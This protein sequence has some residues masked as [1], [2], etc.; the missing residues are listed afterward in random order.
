MSAA[1]RP[2]FALLFEY[3]VRS[4]DLTVVTHDGRALRFGD[5]TGR[6]V[7]IRFAD[8]KAGRELLLDPALKAGELFMDRRLLIE[9]GTVYDLLD[10]MLRDLRNMQAPAVFRAFDALKMAVWRWFP[11]NKAKRSREN[12][13]HHYDLNEALY[14][15][16]L[17]PDYQYS[18]AYFEDPAQSLEDAQLA[19]KRHIAAKLRLEPSSRVLD[20]G[21]GWGGL[22]IYLARTAGAARVTGTSLSKEQ[23]E[24]SRTRVRDAGLED[25][26][27]FRNEDY[28]A[29]KGPF[30]RVVSVGMF[31]HVGLGFYDVFFRTVRSLLAEDGLMLLHTIG[32]AGAPGPTNPWIL[33]YIFPGG[34]VP[35]LSDIVTST[36]RAGLVVIDVETLG[37]H[38]A[39]TLS[40]WRRNFMQR[41]D[42]AERMFDDRF[43]RMWEFY[44]S[45]SEVAFR[46]DDVTLFQLQLARSRSAA[47]LTRSYLSQAEADLRVRERAA[48]GATG[49][50]LAAPPAG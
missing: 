41:R 6:P 3:A 37:P 7:R 48:S 2:V 19:K 26:I 27:T 30:D 34:H 38:Y 15:L 43:C 28:R 25:R 20:I 1:M 17:D 5:G 31:E 23:I 49:W 45:L 40:I 39:Q 4:G 32:S 42:E 24:V 22:A 44:L 47:P 33:K 50:P 11:R 35:S 46:T 9:Q 13:A 14:G 36:E 10:L 29:T 21:S 16:F 12:V 18:C 8:R